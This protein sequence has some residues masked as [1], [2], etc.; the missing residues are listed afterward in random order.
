MSPI[1]QTIANVSSK[2]YGLIGGGTKPLVKTNLI[3]QLDATSSVSYPGSGTTWYDLSGTNNN[4]TL[5]N[6]SA[7]NSSG[8]KYMDFNGSYG[9]AYTSTDITL[10]S[11]VTYM[12][13]T[14]VKNSTSDWRTLTRANSGS[15]NHHV[16]IESGSYRLGMYNNS[17]QNSPSAFNDSGFLQTNLPNYGTSNWA[18]L[19]WRFNT[20]SP[21]YQFSY[22]DTPGTIRGSSTA[23]GSQYN[24]TGFGSI[25]AYNANNGS[26]SQFWGDISQFYAYNRLLTDAELLQ[27]F[28]ATRS[29][30]GI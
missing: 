24:T 15:G 10:A 7:F 27:N 11:T 29:K 18:C 1:N 26:P 13:W 12:V 8:P 5:N 30:F 17:G 3:L 23:T 9:A 21:Y 2:E 28:N 4:F 20:S 14:R 22:N 16:I 25:G 19:Y 6:A